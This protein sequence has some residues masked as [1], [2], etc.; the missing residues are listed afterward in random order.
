MPGGALINPASPVAL[1]PVAVGWTDGMESSRFVAKPHLHLV[2]VALVICPFFSRC[3]PQV[4]PSRERWYMLAALLDRIALPG[5]QAAGRAHRVKSGTTN[6]WYGTQCSG[7]GFPGRWEQSTTSFPN[8]GRPVRPQVSKLG[9][10]AGGFYGRLADPLVGD[11]AGCWS[12]CDLQ[13]DMI[14]PGHASPSTG[15]REGRMHCALFADA[16]LMMFGGVMD[17]CRRCRARSR[18]GVTRARFPTSRSRTQFGAM[19][20]TMVCSARLFT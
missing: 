18:R 10:G 15:T 19:V 2:G 3:E 12:R 7:C 14:I 9:S 8:L 20:L 17:I 4:E 16:A 11:G 5:G 6:W 1:A 13:A